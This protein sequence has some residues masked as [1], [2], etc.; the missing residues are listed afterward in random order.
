MTGTIKKENVLESGQKYHKPT[1]FLLIWLE[2]IHF[3][4]FFSRTSFVC[5]EFSSHDLALPAIEKMHPWANSRHAAGFEGIFFW[6]WKVK[7]N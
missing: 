6:I 2:P 7:G 5:G 4:V 3:L 1:G